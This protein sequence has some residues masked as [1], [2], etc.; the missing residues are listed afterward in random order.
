MKNF[1]R[2]LGVLIFVLCLIVSLYFYANKGYGALGYILL[3]IENIIKTFIGNSPLKLADIVGLKLSDTS[4]VNS[5]FILI[6]ALIIYMAPIFLAAAVVSEFTS[7]RIKF[8]KFFF[9]INIKNSDDDIIIFGYNDMVRDF[10][11]NKIDKKEKTRIIVVSKEEISDK[12]TL[13][14]IRNK[15]LFINKNILESNENDKKEIYEIMN[16]IENIYLF[17]K[18]DLVNYSYLIDVFNYYE[19]EEA[20]KENKKNCIKLY[21]YAEDYQANVMISKYIN[22]KLTKKNDN[23]K[24]NVLIS[25]YNV[26]DVSTLRIRQLLNKKELTINKY[27]KPNTHSIIIGFGNLGHAVFNEVLNKSVYNQN[28]KIRIDIISNDIDKEKNYIL[29]RV[30]GSYIKNPKINGE[31]DENHLE[32]SSDSELGYRCDGQLDIW[33]HKENIENKSFYRTINGILQDNKGDIDNIFMCT[34]ESSTTIRAMKALQDLNITHSEL[35]KKGVNVFLRID[36]N[37]TLYNNVEKVTNNNDYL[38]ILKIPSAKEVLHTNSIENKDETKKAIAFNYVYFIIS[39]EINKIIN[40]KNSS[41]NEI[42]DKVNKFKE[43]FK[44]ADVDKVLNDKS[45]D[46]KED[47]VKK[48]VV[49]WKKSD[50]ASR[51]ATWWSVLHLKVKKELLDNEKLYDK[52]EIKNELEELFRKKF[53]SKESLIKYLNEASDIK[54]FDFIKLEHRRWCYMKALDGFHY[55]EVAN[56]DQL[57]HNCLLTYDKLKE[58]VPE[59][60]LKDLIPLIYEFCEDD[61]K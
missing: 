20:K 32:L 51:E 40:N 9:N 33:F 35:F 41:W 36:N 18:D 3:V 27:D 15:I 53:D 30:S 38:N 48:G 42:K 14:Y 59:T 31:R 12:E 25:D 16:N 34:G 46:A 28:G 10:L 13:R 5:L 11:E 45:N 23:N 26:F 8:R 49:E 56:R 52:K 37:Y 22:E 21:C 6:Y 2:K 57:K 44:N 19:K 29:N 47:D 55:D 60:I 24:L 58:K 39:D 7:F 50:Y 4:F 1:K 61:T 43:N 54:L 17:E